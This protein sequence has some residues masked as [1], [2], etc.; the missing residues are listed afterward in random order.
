MSTLLD[1]RP[2][3]SRQSK[4]MVDGEDGTSHLAQELHHDLIRALVG[5]TNLLNH[6]YRTFRLPIAP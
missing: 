2:G 3:L 4:L 6:V 5:I 1:D